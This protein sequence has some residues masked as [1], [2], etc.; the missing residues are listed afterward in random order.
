MSVICSNKE[1]WIN[2]VLEIGP[3][4][5]VEV[6]NLGGSPSRLPPFL[7]FLINVLVDPIRCVVFGVKITT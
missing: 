1:F 2:D 4:V 6:G 3:I 7:H 5:R